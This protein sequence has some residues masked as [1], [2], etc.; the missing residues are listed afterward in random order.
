[1]T[2]PPGYEPTEDIAA[3][4]RHREVVGS[5]L[6]RRH[7]DRVVRDFMDMFPGMPAGRILEMARAFIADPDGFQ[8]KVR[9]AH[10]DPITLERLALL[11][12]ELP[13][14]IKRQHREE[15]G[16]VIMARQRWHKQR[17]LVSA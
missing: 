8:A 1:M 4:E 11:M 7:R 5:H 10:S 13:H 12:K 9:K 6:P 2:A 15:E 3:P 14:G 17:G 16:P